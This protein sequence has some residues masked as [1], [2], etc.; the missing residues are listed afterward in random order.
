MGGEI[1]DWPLHIRPGAHRSPGEWSGP[2]TGGLANARGSG[3]SPCSRERC[4]EWAGTWWWTH[5]GAWRR[6]LRTSAGSLAPP[7]GRPRTSQGAARKAGRPAA[8]AESG[9]K[10]PLWEASS[11]RLGAHAGFLAFSAGPRGAWRGRQPKGA[12]GRGGSLRFQSPR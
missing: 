3:L 2:L 1:A 8:W 6:A 9:T 11:R 10:K 4:T 12:V 7:A 5:A